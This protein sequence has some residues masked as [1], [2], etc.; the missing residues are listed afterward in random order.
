LAVHPND[1]TDLVSSTGGPSSERRAD[2]FRTTQWTQLLVVRDGAPSGAAHA[3]LSNLCESYWRPIYIYLRRSG[4]SA[5]DAEDL[6]QGFFEHLLSR[7]WLRNVQPENGKFRSFLLKSLKNYRQNVRTKERAEKR[8]GNRTPIPLDELS[9]QEEELSCASDSLTPEQSFD[10]SWAQALMQRAIHRLRAEYVQNGKGDLY[11][12]LKD[13]DLYERGGKSYAQI[14]AEFALSESA[15]K[16]AV[17][18]MRA[19]LGNI[20]RMEIHATLAD[21]AQSQEELIFLQE[22]LRP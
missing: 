18:R 21:P 11:N 2:W 3:G 19:R 15:I 4:F 6:T 7:D 20:I 12:A 22:V 10:R 1:S 14:G 13:L 17:R 8:G 9:R 5:A 16:S